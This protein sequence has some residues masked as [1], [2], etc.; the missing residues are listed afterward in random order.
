MARG[1]GA[2]TPVSVAVLSRPP[3]PREP[4]SEPRP[5]SAGRLPESACQPS[6]AVRSSVRRVSGR[7]CGLGRPAWGTAGR[8]GERSGSEPRLAER[9]CRERRLR[10]QRGEGRAAGAGLLAGQ[11]PLAPPCPWSA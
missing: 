6:S 11:G 7:E 8:Y 10:G 9:G 4:R 2:A 5:V 3:Q 1:P